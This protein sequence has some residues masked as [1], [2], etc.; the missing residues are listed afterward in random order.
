MAK[1]YSDFTEYGSNCECS[2]SLTL[3]GVTVVQWFA[4][5]CHSNTVLCGWDVGFLTAGYLSVC[6]SAR[7]GCTWPRAQCHLGSDRAP[8]QHNKGYVE[9]NGLDGVTFWIHCSLVLLCWLLF[10]HWTF[11]HWTF[12]PSWRLLTKACQ[13]HWPQVYRTCSSLTSS[14]FV[15]LGTWCAEET[16]FQ[17]LIVN[18]SECPSESVQVSG[19]RT[20]VLISSVLSVI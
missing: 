20:S 14:V 7:P 18:R 2:T 12:C 1:T 16:A 11:Y 8:L 9:E 5:V 19:Y 13:A 3:M 4:V 6:M 15:C 17:E 10:Y